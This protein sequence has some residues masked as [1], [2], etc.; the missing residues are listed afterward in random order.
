MGEIVSINSLALGLLLLSA[1][2]WDFGFAAI[3]H[4][5]GYVSMKKMV[6]VVEARETVNLRSYYTGNPCSV[7]GLSVYEIKKDPQFRLVIFQG[8]V[9]SQPGDANCRETEDIIHAANFELTN[10]NNERMFIEVLH[11]DYA[12]FELR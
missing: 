6:V 7:G 4:D 10:E 3:V 1:I 8:V 2:G 11:P 12:E 5:E 9:R